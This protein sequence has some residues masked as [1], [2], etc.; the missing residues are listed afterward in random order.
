MD[1]RTFSDLQN[2][3]SEV[4][5]EWDNLKLT[6]ENWTRWLNGYF[7]TW[8]NK[9]IVPQVSEGEISLS[10]MG[11]K[12]RGIPRIVRTDQPDIDWLW[13]YNFQFCDENA[14]REGE[15]PSEPPKVVMQFYLAPSTEPL[16][17]QSGGDPMLFRDSACTEL[18]CKGVSDDTPR[19]IAGTM[20]R[21]MLEQKEKFAP[22]PL[23]R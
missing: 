17:R 3:V 8:S 9:S 10:L 11:T 15:K 5:G 18:I 23:N 1:P 7:M 20:A 21:I 12:L 16:V 6:K 22:A 4:H 14:N 13:E 2:R 19:Y